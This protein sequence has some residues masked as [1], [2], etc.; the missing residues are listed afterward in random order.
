MWTWHNIWKL[1]A[2]SLY[3]VLYCN[4]F[5]ISDL[6]LLYCH[7]LCI[8]KKTHYLPLCVHADAIGFT[9]NHIRSFLRGRGWGIYIY[10]L[11]RLR[12]VER[13][14]VYTS[15]TLP[16]TEPTH[17]WTGDW[18]SGQTSNRRSA[19]RPLLERISQWHS[20]MSYAQP[21]KWHD[22]RAQTMGTWIRAHVDTSKTVRRKRER[23]LDQWE[24]S[25]RVSAETGQRSLL[26]LLT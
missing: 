26:L 4:I 3:Y 19:K 8:Y 12:V 21:M 24:L 15:S 6:S 10:L 20:R 23:R 18:V 25:W 5:Y 16:D 2:T 14:C 13:A 17:E 22:S 1:I 11:A 7:C 9:W